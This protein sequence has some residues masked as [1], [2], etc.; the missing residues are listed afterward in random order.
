MLKPNRLVAMATSGKLTENAR[1]NHRTLCRGD[2]AQLPINSVPPG[3]L[4]E[5]LTNGLRRLC[6][7]A[8]APNPQV[9]EL[10]SKAII[11]WTE[12]LDSVIGGDT[13]PPNKDRDSTAVHLLTAIALYLELCRREPTGC[14]T[15]VIA[16]AALARLIRACEGHVPPEAAARCPA[17]RRF[18]SQYQ[19][20]RPA[21][22][23]TEH[24][25]AA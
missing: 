8:F 4:L 13:L 16:A 7:L 1:A 5:S 6:E 14:T 17:L 15:G 20:P 10:A 22:T 3:A 9:H 2:K 18:L 11:T 25:A 21:T 24:I 19:M 12:N 23:R